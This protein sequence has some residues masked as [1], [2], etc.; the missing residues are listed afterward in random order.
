MYDNGL[1]S[2]LLKMNQLITWMSYKPESRLP[3]EIP[4][5]S[6]MQMIYHSNDRKQRE[7]KEPLEGEE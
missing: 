4:T 1:N 7:T 5:T 3:G 6:D 2:E